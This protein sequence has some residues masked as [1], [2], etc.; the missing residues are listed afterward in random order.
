[1]REATTDAVKCF[2][3]SRNVAEEQVPEGYVLASFRCVPQT[4]WLAP[5]HR[6]GGSFGPRLGADGQGPG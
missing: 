2:V 1:V 3:G 5:E 6:P 4:W